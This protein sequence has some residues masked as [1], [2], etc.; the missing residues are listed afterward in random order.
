MD[1]KEGTKRKEQAMKL[2]IVT[3]ANKGLGFE[4]AKQLRAVLGE[5]YEVLL[6][7]RNENLGRNSVA[8]LAKQGLKVA[9]HNLSETWNVFPTTI[10]LLTLTNGFTGRLLSVRYQR[11]PECI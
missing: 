2:A 10:S 3:G 7:S 8:K 1:T 9:T 11:S 6:T 4:S 5:E